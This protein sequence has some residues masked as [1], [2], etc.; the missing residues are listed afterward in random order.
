[1]SDT[2]AAAIGALRRGEL[3][4]VPT[5]TVYGLAA[6]VGSP[7][8]ARRLYA[9]KGRPA[10]MPT[11]LV[12]ASVDDL[13]DLVPELRGRMASVLRA[14]LPGAFTLVVPNPGRRFAWICGD[15]PEAV[16]VRVPALAGR[17]AELLAAVGAVTATSANL[18]G[19]RDPCTVDDVPVELRAGVGATLDT[20]PLPGSP[21]TVVDLSGAEPAVLREGAVPATATLE[22]VARALA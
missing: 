18:P 8:P 13:L 21:S 4:I 16:G 3:A 14:L 10:G 19:G 5:D 17:A 22:R 11:A 12:A 15:R 1:V 6:T 9:L 2:V 7:E 20:G